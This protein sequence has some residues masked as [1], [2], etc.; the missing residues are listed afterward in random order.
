VQKFPAL[1]CVQKFP[2]LVCVQKTPR[3]E[4]QKGLRAKIQREGLLQAGC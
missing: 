3:K 4:K 1:V 2:A